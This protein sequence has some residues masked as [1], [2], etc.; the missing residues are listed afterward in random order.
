MRAQ[1]AA[2]AVMCK[3]VVE[4]R[5]PVTAAKVVTARSQG[6]AYVVVLLLLQV[7]HADDAP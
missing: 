2:A 5:W 1:H 4:R 7:S 3:H 6:T